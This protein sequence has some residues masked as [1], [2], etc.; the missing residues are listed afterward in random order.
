MFFFFLIILKALILNLQPMWRM[1][2]SDIHLCSARLPGFQGNLGGAQKAK[3]PCSFVSWWFR[4]QA[5]LSLQLANDDGEMELQ[6][7]GFGLVIITGRVVVSFK[8]LSCGGIYTE[9]N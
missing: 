9:S 6:E 5:L 8:C 1:H 3:K 7:V 2:S 4:G